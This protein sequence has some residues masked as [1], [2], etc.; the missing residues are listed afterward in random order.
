MFEGRLFIGSAEANATNSVAE[1]PN[2]V[3]N[4]SANAY[5]IGTTTRTCNTDNTV[6]ITALY[7]E[8]L[9]G[10]GTPAKEEIANSI[11]HLQVQYGIDD[12]G[13]FAVNQYFNANSI[14]NN[15]ATTP[16]W[17]Q[18]ISVR[19]WVLARA[20]CPTAG[21]TNAKTYVMGDQ[22]YIPNDAFKRQLY[23]S[24]VSL[25]NGI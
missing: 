13:D 4:L 6:P 18:V 1:T 2:S 12:S 25:R 3:Q 16:N 19:F 7:R 22:N 15:T 21:Y 24:T 5:Y 23:S 9:N 8:A 17:N 20:E 14:S 10:S 11:E